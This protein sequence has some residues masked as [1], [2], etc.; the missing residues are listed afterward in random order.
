MYLCANLYN[1]TRILEVYISQIYHLFGI[2]YSYLVKISYSQTRKLATSVKK[3]EK[4]EN[5]QKIQK[6][7]YVIKDNVYPIIQFFIKC[8]Q[9][10]FTYRWYNFFF[11]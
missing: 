4:I 9:I 3:F 6:Y 10:M 7:I 8:F 2:P 5:F 11:L 1:C